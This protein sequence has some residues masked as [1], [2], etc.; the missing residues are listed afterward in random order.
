MPLLLASYLFNATEGT[1][2]ADA[3]Q[4][5]NFA[6]SERAVGLGEDAVEHG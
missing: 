6:H 2:L 1:H 4:G 5:L 3:N